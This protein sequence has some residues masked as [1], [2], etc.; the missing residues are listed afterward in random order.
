MSFGV[1]PSLELITV[2]GRWRLRWGGALGLVALETRFD[3]SF[4]CVGHSD[5]IVYHS[6]RVLELRHI[7]RFSV[8]S[9]A[10]AA[11]EAFEPV[12]LHVRNFLRRY[13]LPF[14]P[15]EED[16]L[17][18]VGVVIER[19]W[20]SRTRIEIRGLGSWWAYVATAARW[21][22]LDRLG[23]PE[24]SEWSEDVPVEDLELIGVVADFAQHRELICT[25][26]R[27]SA[28][29]RSRAEHPMTLT[30]KAQVAGGTVSLFTRAPVGR[31]RRDS[32]ADGPH[33]SRLAR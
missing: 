30:A 16:R 2:D 4:I 14:L 10:S 25:V 3:P 1:L 6:M 21:C 20:T 18:V 28:V 7:E 19:L 29:A 5:L 24:E 22:T 9:D 15:N 23:K 17:E 13:L 31:Y 12:A 26:A 33:L 11:E 27:M 8:S 32:W